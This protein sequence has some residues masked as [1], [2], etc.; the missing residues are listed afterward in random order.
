VGVHKAREDEFAIFEAYE[1]HVERVA[2]SKNILEGM[3]GDVLHD[4]VNIAGWA[5]SKKTPRQSI[6]GRM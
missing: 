5:D 4:P 1:G 6:E 3:L 2:L